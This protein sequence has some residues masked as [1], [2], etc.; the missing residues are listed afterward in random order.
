MYRDYDLAPGIA[1]FDEAGT[2]AVDFEAPILHE[3]RVTQVYRQTYQHSI[4]ADS[5]ELPQYCSKYSH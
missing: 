5:L 4:S 3:A 1:D 2:D